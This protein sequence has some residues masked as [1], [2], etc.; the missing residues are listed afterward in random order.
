MCPAGLFISAG[1]TKQNMSSSIDI[2]K[3]PQGRRRKSPRQTNRKR[4]R[5]LVGREP[6]AG[7]IVPDLPPS[8]IERLNARP[9]VRAECREGPRPC[10]WVGCR[11][12]LYLDTYTTG[13]PENPTPGLII[14]RPDVDPLDLPETC[15]LDLADRG[16]YTLAQIGEIFDLS[17]ERIRQIEANALRKLARHAN[18][19][20]PD[21]VIRL[22]ETL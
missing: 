3:R 22:L 5:F 14:H 9:H 17:R 18:I 19:R 13:D 21:D 16:P 4:R 8:L 7:E 10:P 6:I 12:H 20:D 1:R 2:I 11:Y 15:L